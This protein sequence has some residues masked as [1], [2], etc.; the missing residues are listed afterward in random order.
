MSTVTLAINGNQGYAADQVE[1]TMTLGDLLSAVKNAI[2]DFGPDTRVVTH[3]GGNPYGANYGS[4]DPY[5]DTFT[6][7]EDDEDK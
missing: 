1:N 2:E 3:D 7:L 4:I 6:P 5:E